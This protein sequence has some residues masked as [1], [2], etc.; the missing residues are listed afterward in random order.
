MKVFRAYLLDG[1]RGGVPMKRKNPYVIDW[2]VDGIYGR[3]GPNLLYVKH[4]WA[5]LN[6]R[7]TLGLYR[8]A[9]YLFA[10]A[11]AHRYLEQPKYRRAF[12]AF[13]D[14]PSDVGGPGKEHTARMRA[15][16]PK[17]YAEWKADLRGGPREWLKEYRV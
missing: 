6:W 16:Q 3:K 8:V 12:Y 13:R 9:L 5:L 14:G 15:A 2:R 10:V 4:L 7:V 17:T 1:G 11:A